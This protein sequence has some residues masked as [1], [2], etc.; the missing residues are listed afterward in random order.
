M[1][2]A[3]PVLMTQEQI[4]VYLRPTFSDFPIDMQ[5]WEVFVDSTFL[6][7]TQGLARGRK[8]WN[9]RP[10]SSM[11]QW[12]SHT[13]PC[14]TTQLT[15]FKANVLINPWQEKGWNQS[16]NN[17]VSAEDFVHSQF[18]RQAPQPSMLFMGSTDLRRELKSLPLLCGWV[19][20]IL[21]LAQRGHFQGTI[22]KPPN[23]D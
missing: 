17:P 8:S 9:S 10:I 23:E 21:T 7:L 18:S 16:K 4:K 20:S 1:V 12:N 22:R 14:P 2:C 15:T 3:G 5:L 6:G 19:Q 13:T 11:S